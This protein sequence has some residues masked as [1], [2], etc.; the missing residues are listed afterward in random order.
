MSLYPSYRMLS[1]AYLDLQQLRI[2]VGAR[3]RKLYGTGKPDPEVL[4]ILK[5]YHARLRS[6]EKELLAEAMKRIGNHP[7]RQWCSIVK[8]LG[9]VAC[10]LLLGYINPEV[11]S[12]G[13]VWAFFGLF[14]GAKLRAGK[15]GKFDP[16]AKGR[17]WVIGRN[18]IMAKDSYYPAIYQAKKE[19]YLKTRKMEEFLQDP[20][21]CPDYEAC[22]QARKRVAERLGR[23]VK[24]APCKGHIDN[25]AKR[26]ML[27]ILLSHALQIIREAAGYD[28]S[29]LK[30]HRGYIKPKESAEERPDSRLLNNIRLGLLE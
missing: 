16:M 25:M 28:V 13:K 17:A 27:K 5:A 15:K 3:I 26:Y 2:A 4:R 12:A 10:L 29:A 19:Y 6:E 23:K 1:R 24:K 21:K 20:A 9:D 7:L 22:L 8:G 14:P 18:V 30:S 11:E